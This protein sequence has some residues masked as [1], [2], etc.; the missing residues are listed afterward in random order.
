[1]SL[2][3]FWFFLFLAVAVS[4]YFLLPQKKYQWIVLLA[5]SC[6]FYCAAS[7]RY[8]AYILFTIASSYG[9]SLWLEGSA[10]RA[11]ALLAQHKADWDRAA[12]KAYRSQIKRRRQWI[13]VL[14]LA[15]NFGVLAVLKY[16]DFALG[17]VNRLTGSEGKLLSLVLPLGISFYTFQTMG[18]L[19]DVYRGNV[20]AER[21]PAK[22]ALFVSFFPQILQGPISNFAQLQPQ[23]LGEH[24]FS[25]KRF[26]SG[27]QRML[28]GYFKKLVVADLLA[29]YVTDVLLNYS[30]YQGLSMWL[31]IF[32]FS[33]RLYADFSGYM[34]IVC[35]L[36]EILGIELRENFDRP[37]FSKSVAEF[38]RRWH[39]SLGDWFKNYLYYP[40]AISGWSQRLSRWGQKRFG[41]SFAR[42]VP[43][44]IALLAVWLM[45]GLWH[46]ASLGFVAW[47]LV[48][49]GV[50][51]LSLWLAPVF[52]RCNHALHLTE[53]SRG[54][55]A[56]RIVRTFVLMAWIEI[57]PETGSLR[58]GL[59]LWTQALRF[60]A[61]PATWAQW[62]PY[63]MTVRRLVV[64]ACGTLLIFLAD[65]LKT[66]EPVRVFLAK[67]PV[68]LLL[69]L[70]LLCALLLF[71]NYGAGYQATDFMYFKY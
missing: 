23:L 24:R 38:W 48:N 70:M 27:A 44:T 6:V 28:W 57:L 51:I 43:A 18:Y 53:E 25:A 49:G 55:Q 1:M 46:G 20:A 17:M 30:S 5:A 40:I 11:E 71:G 67:R 63:G 69:V 37:F 45:T 34:D 47:G 2:T 32:L 50:I 39:I 42:T 60:G 9:I 29:P 35:G 64:I 8:G 26:G 10:H 19:I 3:S 7:F 21:N 4:V 33:I 66:K 58:G 41:A 54:F 61:V 65:L 62:F 13:L 12:K 16:A 15:L 56:F 14:G 36:C 31:G 22:L 52:T 68:R 59:G